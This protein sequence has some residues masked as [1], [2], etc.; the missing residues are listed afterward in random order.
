MKT[1]KALYKALKTNLSKVH[2]QRIETGGMGTGVPDV[3]GCWQGKEFWLELK[4]GSLQSVNLSPQ[5]CAWHMRRANVGGLSW[6]LIH[7]P[8][9]HF[10][11]LVPGVESINLRARH[12][13]SSKFIEVQEPPYDWKDLLKRICMID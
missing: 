7:D 6:I 13:S 5:Q 9:K 10:L 12:L 3:N 1:E 8:S 4:I 11:W 2:W